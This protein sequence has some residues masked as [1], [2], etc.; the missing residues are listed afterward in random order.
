MFHL[1]S[2]SYSLPTSEYDTAVVNTQRGKSGAADFIDV[3]AETK[4]EDDVRNLS[5]YVEFVATKA[6]GA[7]STG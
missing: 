5:V 2:H 1:V 3:Q 7:D 4:I 6:I